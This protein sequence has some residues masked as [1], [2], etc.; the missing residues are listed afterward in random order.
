METG[1]SHFGSML[2][3]DMSRPE[4]SVRTVVP[5]PAQANFT[6]RDPPAWRNLLLDDPEGDSPTIGMFQ[7]RVRQESFS[8]GNFREG[9]SAVQSAKQ[10]PAPCPIISLMLKKLIAMPVRR[11]VSEGSDGV[12]RKRTAAEKISP[13]QVHWCVN[14]SGITNPARRLAMD[15]ASAEVKRTRLQRRTCQTMAGPRWQTSGPRSYR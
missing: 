5:T 6:T 15:R 14:L 3:P 8:G 10:C 11:H 4:P 2:F 7:K 13:R 1:A 9:I 12:R